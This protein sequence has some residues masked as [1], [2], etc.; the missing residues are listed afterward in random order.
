MPLT[1]GSPFLLRAISQLQCSGHVQV[2]SDPG[3][4]LYG[5]GVP[6]GEIAWTG[7]AAPLT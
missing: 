7:I 2:T 5:A 4:Q 6:A 1:K 3:L